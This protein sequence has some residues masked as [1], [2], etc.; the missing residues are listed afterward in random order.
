MA[1][2][3]QVTESGVLGILCISYHNKELL[4]IRLRWCKRLLKGLGGTKNSKLRRRPISCNTQTNSRTLTNSKSFG[5]DA[6][7]A[8][9]A[10]EGTNCRLVLEDFGEYEEERSAKAVAGSLCV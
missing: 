8:E 10:L 3:G 1:G 2:L 6:E 4:P 7:E 5:H 9:T